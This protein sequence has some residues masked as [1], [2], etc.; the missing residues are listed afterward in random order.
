VP[1]KMIN[2]AAPI[3]RMLLVMVVVAFSVGVTYT[4]ITGDIGMLQT[5]AAAEKKITKALTKTVNQIAVRQAV[6]QTKLE[7]EQERSKEFRQATARALER[8]LKK[9]DK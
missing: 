1:L 6:I 4:V 5:A 8:I 9:L 2:E 7:A 3:V